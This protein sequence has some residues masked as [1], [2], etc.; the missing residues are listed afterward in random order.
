MV[1]HLRKP[2]VEPAQRG[3]PVDP[4]LR[5][6]CPERHGF[7]AQHR[8]NIQCT[9]EEGDAPR[10]SFGIGRDQSRFVLAPR[11]EQVAR[12]GLDHA[13]EPELVE[14]RRHPLR[15]AL[16]VVGERIEMVMV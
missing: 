16:P 4:G 5:H 6:P 14:Q 10:T 7:A 3:V 9:I 13:A 1:E 12:A 2:A 8:R 15:L 11:I